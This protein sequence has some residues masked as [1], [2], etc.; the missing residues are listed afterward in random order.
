[1]IG[2]EY[3]RLTSDSV[4]GDEAAGAM[5]AAL[6]RRPLFTDL[7]NAEESSYAVQGCSGHC[8]NTGRAMS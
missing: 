7:R 3:V 1:M 4:T 8:C 6:R 2:W 5:L